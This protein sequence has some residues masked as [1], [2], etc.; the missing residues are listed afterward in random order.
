MEAQN[1]ISPFRRNSA[2]IENRIWN[3]KTDGE[4]DELREW[5]PEDVERSE[6]GVV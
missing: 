6:Y 1:R 3:R 4:M 5:L 2:E